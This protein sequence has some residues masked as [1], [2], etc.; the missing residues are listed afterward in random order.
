[1]DS[2]A[3]ETLLLTDLYEWESDERVGANGWPRRRIE[4]A[5]PDRI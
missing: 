4:G 2:L 1:M 5:R 3:A